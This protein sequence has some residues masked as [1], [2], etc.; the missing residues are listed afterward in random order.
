MNIAK[1]DLPSTVIREAAADMLKL[2]E[3]EVQIDMGEWVT[4]NWRTGGVCSACLGGAYLLGKYPNFSDTSEIAIE[5]LI[6]DSATFCKVVMLN[7]VRSGYIHLGLSKYLGVFKERRNLPRPEL[8][9]EIHPVSG[10]LTPDRVRFLYEDLN[11]LA[12][13]LERIHL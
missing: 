4:R 13:F 9:P 3:A 10:E 11:K 8:Y 1:E 7:S 2:S 12:D 5:S 6:A